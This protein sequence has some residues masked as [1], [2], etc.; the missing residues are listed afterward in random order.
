MRRKKKVDRVIEPDDKYESVNVSKFINYL[1]KGGKKSV[2]RKVMYDALRQVE[3]KTKQVPLPVFDL[4]LQNVTPTQEVKSRRIGGATYQVPMEVRGER[5]LYLA[6]TWLIRA[7]RAQ[8]GKPM[9][10]RLSFEFIAASKNEGEAVRKKENTHRM[11]EANR[12]F[13]HFAR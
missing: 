12:A 2:A 7:A 9:A 10:D 13:A 4:A 5:K 3:Q 6:I 11:A 1:M 8:K